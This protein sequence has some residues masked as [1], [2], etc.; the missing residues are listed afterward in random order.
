M[1]TVR[2]RHPLPLHG[3]KEADMPVYVM[4]TSL[5]Q[6]GARTV[7]TTPERIK[8]VDKELEGYGVRVLQQYATLGRYDFVNIV[9]A[10]DNLTMAKASLEMAARGSVRI[11][12][13]AAIPVD[14]LIARLK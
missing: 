5:T 10:P 13:L 12:T 3:A 2:R 4:L 14:N 1:L 6:D 7:K 9:E 11:E 8:V